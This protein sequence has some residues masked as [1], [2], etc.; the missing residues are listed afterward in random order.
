MTG[1]KGDWHSSQAAALASP[2]GSKNCLMDRVKA[3]RRSVKL[4]TGLLGGFEEEKRRRD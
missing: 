1:T 3:V 4:T 2:G